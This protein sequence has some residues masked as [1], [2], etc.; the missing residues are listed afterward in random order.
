MF[1][2]TSKSMAWH[3]GSMAAGAW[4]MAVFA[5]SNA[6]DIY[7][8]VGQFKKIWGDLVVLS[9]MLAPLLAAGG[10][11]YRTWGS[12][13]VPQA[14]VAVAP[15]YSPS[16]APFVLMP[17]SEDLSASISAACASVSLRRLVMMTATVA[18]M[19]R[20]TAIHVGASPFRHAT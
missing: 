14:S 12:K 5:Q 6:V 11:A 18:R 15:M 2:L 8:M 4:G 20:A 3:V 1:G 19:A 7:A 17:P 13:Q 16:S 10:V 9:S